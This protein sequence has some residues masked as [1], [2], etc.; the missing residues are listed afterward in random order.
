MVNFH[1]AQ[2]PRPLAR[3]PPGGGVAGDAFV[4]AAQTVLQMQRNAEEHH[5]VAAEAGNLEEWN[6]Y[7]AQATSEERDRSHLGRPIPLVILGFG[8]PGGRRSLSTE[9]VR[10]IIASRRQLGADFGVYFPVMGISD[11]AG[12]FSPHNRMPYAFAVAA[13]LSDTGMMQ[14][15]VG[16]LEEGHSL[17]GNGYANTKD[18]VE[19][20][21]QKGCVVLDLAE[22]KKGQSKSL[23]GLLLGGEKGYYGVVL[24]KRS[25]ASS[26]AI[27]RA[28]PDDRL[29]RLTAAD[30]EAEAAG[31]GAAAGA[32][33]P[34]PLQK[35]ALALLR[36]IAAWY[37]E[38]PGVQAEA[39]RAQQAQHEYNSQPMRRREAERQAAELAAM[40]GA[41]L[42]PCG[43]GSEEVAEHMA[44]ILTVAL[45]S[46]PLALAKLQRGDVQSAMAIGNLLGVAVGS[47]AT[48]QD[49][50]AVATF[51]GDR[52]LDAVVQQMAAAR[53]RRE[54]SLWRATMLL[55]AN[56]TRFSGQA[57]DG[58]RRRLLEQGLGP[59]LLIAAASKDAHTR[60]A[61]GAAID[62]LKSWEAWE[63]RCH[64]CGRREPA[65]AEGPERLALCAGCRSRAFCG[66]DCQLACWK[67]HKRECR[68]LAAL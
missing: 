21:G 8:A 66:R 23:P 3:A 44:G 67:E 53:Q 20:A 36:R 10:Q 50:A 33:A 54:Y 6:S 19:N 64:G 24:G 29:L 12:S 51:G 22:D 2:M 48:Q 9:L 59:E 68:E 37:K 43:C 47:S 45:A 38:R 13:G 55:A 5:R 15:A 46:P 61:A 40:P 14:V 30:L 42:C 11:G 57:G 39:A 18:V 27:G 41:P 26:A 60:D 1:W 7:M 65:E 34:D 25:E 35:Q 63:R 58:Y 56:C 16:T 31:A 62:G 32:P 17:R 28:Y 52:L 49:P 4:S